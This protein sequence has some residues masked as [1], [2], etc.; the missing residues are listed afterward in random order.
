MGEGD[1]GRAGLAWR[2]ERG[3]LW[4]PEWG[5]EKG[6]YEISWLRW[7]DSA[8]L[9]FLLFFLLLQLLGGCRYHPCFC[10]ILLY[11]WVVAR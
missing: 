1:A 10:V 5:A 7:L 3:E 6:V 2:E 8:A 11:L 9:V 4:C